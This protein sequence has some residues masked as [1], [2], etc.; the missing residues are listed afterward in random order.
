[1]PFQFERC[2]QSVD[3]F[4]QDFHHAIVAAIDHNFADPDCARRLN[5]HSRVG[6]RDPGPGHP[7]KTFPHKFKKPGAIIVP[8][9]PVIVADEIGNSFPISAIDRMKEMFRVQADLMLR[10]PKPQQIQPDAQCNG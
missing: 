7:S 10:S 5:P 1:M 8:L 4:V 3:A 6:R 2:R 9:V